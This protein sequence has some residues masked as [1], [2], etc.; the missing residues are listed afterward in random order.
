[1]TEFLLFLVS[2]VAWFVLLTWLLGKIPKRYDVWASYSDGG[3]FHTEFSF[4]S[5]TKFFQWLVFRGDNH[6][7]TT[8]VVIEKKV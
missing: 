3:W 4:L 2:S 8:V 1:M 5:Q 7:H 6:D